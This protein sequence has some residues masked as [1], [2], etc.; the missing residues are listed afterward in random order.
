MNAPRR[1]DEIAD[2]RAFVVSFPKTGRTWV[3]MLLGRALCWSHGLPEELIFSPIEL[4]RA[5]GVL[6]TVFTHDKAI[7][8]EETN[9]EPF[10]SDKSRYVGKRIIFLVR[11]PRD[12]VVSL[13]FHLTRRTVRFHGTLSEFIRSNEFGMPA[14]MRYY[15]IWDK[16]RHVPERFE[17]IR[18]EDLVRDSAAEL[19][20]M[21]EVIGAEGIEEKVIARVV[22]SC[23]FESLKQAE[24]EGK[25]DHPKMRPG[26]P[27]DPESFKVRRG[28]VGGYRDYLSQEDLDYVEGVIREAGSGIWPG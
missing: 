4:T 12:A 26:D 24:R 27:N 10:S 1:L 19:R 8:V 21:L 22:E 6:T 17:I 3:R 9:F 2:L 18:Y 25:I 7:P 20:R 16:N 23:S 14:I 11:D 15:E 13:Y 28:K 5:A